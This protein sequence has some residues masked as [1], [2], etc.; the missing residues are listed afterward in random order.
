MLL[1]GRIILYYLQIMSRKAYQ[2]SKKWTWFILKV[3][4][5]HSILTTSTFIH[6]IRNR[7]LHLRWVLFGVTRN[8]NCVS[9]NFLAS[10]QSDFYVNTHDARSAGAPKP[11]PTPKSDEWFVSFIQLKNHRQLKTVQPKPNSHL[12]NRQSGLIIS[13]TLQR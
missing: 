4:V 5:V 8:Q 7:T 9:T 2:T 3:L 11:N 12:G 6:F 13:L 1:K 10:F